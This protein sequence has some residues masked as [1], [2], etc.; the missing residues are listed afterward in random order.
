VRRYKI[1]QL[2][3]LGASLAAHIKTEG[4]GCNFTNKLV[5]HNRSWSSLK[6]HASCSSAEGSK[7]LKNV[8]DQNIKICSGIWKDELKVPLYASLNFDPWRLLR[9]R[10]IGW[11]IPQV[12]SAYGT[13]RFIAQ[14]RVVRLTEQA[15]QILA[16]CCCYSILLW[17]VEKG[18]LKRCGYGAAEVWMLR[19]LGPRQSLLPLFEQISRRFVH[20]AQD[21]S[22]IMCST[23]GSPAASSIFCFV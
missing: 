15:T 3:S 6:D 9:H 11:S 23:T 21:F 12:R 1:A 7:A 5:K 20:V 14:P 10:L 2:G 19:P 13:I 4:Y 18:A 8:A 16:G 17:G 22:P